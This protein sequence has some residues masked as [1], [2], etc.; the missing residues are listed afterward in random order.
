MRC[1]SCE[2]EIENDNLLFCERC[3]KRKSAGL[4]AL[5]IIVPFIFSSI[6]LEIKKYIILG[7]LPTMLL[8]CLFFALE[9]TI[10]DRFKETN[11]KGEIDETVLTP[12]NETNEPISDSLNLNKYLVGRDISPGKVEITP[13]DCDSYIKIKSPNSIRSNRLIQITQPK[14]IRL[15]KGDCISLYNCEFHH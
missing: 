15:K 4:I 3:R 11:A 1:L 14:R 8:Y 7:F 6:L 9:K 10:W 2:K 5:L 12:H 13:T